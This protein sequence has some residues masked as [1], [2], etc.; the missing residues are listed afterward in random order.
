M[1][2]LKNGETLLFLGDSI[3]DC[4]RHQNG[5]SN[6]GTGYPN[7]FSAFFRVRYPEVLINFIN[8]G[9]G[10]NKTPDILARLQTDVLDLHPD[11]VTLLIGINDVWRFY[12]NPGSGFGVSAEDYREN[13]KKIIEPTLASGARMLI[14]TPYFIDT[15]PYEPMRTQVLEYAAICKQIVR[16]YEIETIELQPVFE[17]L[18]KRG[19]TSYILS[20]DRVHPKA[21]GHAA[22]AQELFKHIQVQH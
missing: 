3:T 22:I 14:M 2:T 15:N 13:L 12:E 8:K 16:Q 9:T 5:I 7:L 18:M 21:A 17:D 4:G 6:L 20:G 1:I 10:G 11:V 19:L